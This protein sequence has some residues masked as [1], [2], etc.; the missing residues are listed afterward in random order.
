MKDKVSLTLEQELLILLSRLTFSEENVC[1][2]KTLVKDN[3]EINWF[4]F[5][6]LALYHK[7]TTL[8]NANLKKFVGNVGYP[9]YLRD[10]IEHA[11]RGI[12]EKNDLY[13]TEISSVVQCLK[14]EDICVIPVKGSML[15]PTMYKDS[16]IRYSVDA[17]FLVKYSDI[18]RLKEVLMRCGYIQGDFDFSTNTLKPLSRAEDIRWKMNMSN[19]YPFVKLND[20]EAV[21]IYGLDF[22]YALDDSL[23]KEPINEIIDHA[24]EFG[25][26]KPAHILT[27]LCTHFYD[28]AKCS[29][30][31]YIAKDM[32]IIKLCDI[33]EYILQFMSAEEIQDCINFAKVYGLKKQIYFTMFFLDLIYSDGYEKEI[34]KKLE[35]DDTDFLHTYGENASNDKFIIKKDFFGRLFSCNNAD[36]LVNKPAILKEL[37]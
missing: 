1:R 29:I 26:P 3:M 37:S 17:D 28:E 8:V 30:S 32:N 25:K 20:N 19:L 16:G 6:K 2:I 36:E 21:R 22:R 35:I 18:A 9:N 34:M 5:Y 11:Y 15:I 33:R 4:E 13:R 12:K 23:S 27:H 31:L 14:E 7:T 24:S 10:V